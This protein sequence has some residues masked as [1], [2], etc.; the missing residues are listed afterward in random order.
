MVVVP[1]ECLGEE[2]E[3]AYELPAGYSAGTI[4]RLVSSHPWQIMVAVLS[5][6]ALTTIWVA[7][8]PGDRFSTDED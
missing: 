6:S 8:S 1:T 2:L 4:A 3:A 5:L 7:L